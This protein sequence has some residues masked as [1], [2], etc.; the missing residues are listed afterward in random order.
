MKSVVSKA[1]NKQSVK[2]GR[3]FR[4]VWE[5]ENERGISE[6]LFMN[7][8]GDLVVTGPGFCKPVTLKESLQWFA[9]GNREEFG[10]MGGYSSDVAA[11]FE[12]A[13]MAAA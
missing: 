11:F 5:F 4:E 13:A 3:G 6:R 7:G 1:K 9:N 10:V 2:P 12:M 8:K